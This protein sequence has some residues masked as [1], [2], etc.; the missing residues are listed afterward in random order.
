MKPCS[1]V[2]QEIS[3]QVRNCWWLLLRVM[4]TFYCRCLWVYAKVAPVHP[5]QMSLFWMFSYPNS[6][7]VSGLILNV[8]RV[9][10]FNV[11]AQSPCFLSAQNHCHSFYPLRHLH[12]QKSDAFAIAIY[13]TAQAGPF[14]TLILSNTQAFEVGLFL[15][16]S[17]LRC[18]F[19]EELPLL[20]LQ[21]L[22]DIV[23]DSK[24]RVLF[25]FVLKTVN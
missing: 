23:T 17:R 14:L 8:F 24:L 10:I 11:F 15:L 2:E 4:I 6:F 18:C 13:I 21:I 25:K 19:G 16:I 5:H 9:Q 1:S 20:A 3:F 7:D 22:T 12:E